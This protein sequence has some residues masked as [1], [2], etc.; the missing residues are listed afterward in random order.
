MNV[1]A[2]KSMTAVKV[3]CDV[4]LNYEETYKEVMAHCRIKRPILQRAL[5][6]LTDL[7]LV[8]KVKVEG[9]R[10]YRLR[11]TLPIPIAT[12]TIL[13]RCIK[14]DEDNDLNAKIQAILSEIGS[15]FPIG[16]YTGKAPNVRQAIRWL[17]LMGNS[18]VQLYGLLEDARGRHLEKSA[19]INYV[20][21]IIAEWDEPTLSEIAAERKRKANIAR[22]IEAKEALEHSL[23]KVG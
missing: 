9:S 23:A 1:S 22:A 7:G 4:I 10:E 13:E 19:P 15:V 6:E 20:E 8:E 18:A 12:S 3:L 21:A 17:S 14:A 16:S 5:Q 2:I 11:A